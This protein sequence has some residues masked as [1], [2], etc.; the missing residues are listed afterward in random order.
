MA[1]SEYLP[2][3]DE[4]EG[5]AAGRR[6]RRGRQGGNRGAHAQE[7]GAAADQDAIDLTR[8][9]DTSNDAANDAGACGIAGDDNHAAFARSLM[10]LVMI[11]S[12][13]QLHGCRTPASKSAAA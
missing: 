9:T 13:S 6:R 1:C 7:E 3:E 12:A 2:S 10:L 8:S 4:E 5:A 11:Q